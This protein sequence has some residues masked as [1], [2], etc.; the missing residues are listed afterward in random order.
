MKIIVC[1]GRDYKNKAFVYKKLDELHAERPI[2]KLMQGGATGADAFA[3]QWAHN[4]KVLNHTYDADW[5]KYG[6]S[7]GPIRNRRMLY[8]GK[9]DLVVAFPGGKGTANML[10]LAREAGVEVITYDEGRLV[11][12]HT[13]GP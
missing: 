11:P 2:T 13:S 12:T 10:K 4:N 9:P 7:A 3:N 8:G 5:K 1:G 6:P